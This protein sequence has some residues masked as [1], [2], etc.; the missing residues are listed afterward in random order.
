MT[1]KLKIIKKENCILIKDGRKKFAEI[2][3]NKNPD[4]KFCVWHNRMC[5][6]GYESEQKAIEKV[7]KLYCDWYGFVDHI[8]SMIE[9]GKSVATYSLNR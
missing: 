6:S 1:N 3:Y 5:F 9:T 7:Q 8:R 2:T 4:Y